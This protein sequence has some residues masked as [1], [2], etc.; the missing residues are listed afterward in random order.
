MCLESSYS[1]LI[2]GG[3]REEV[4]SHLSQGLPCR[5]DLQGSMTLLWETEEQEAKCWEM[6]DLLDPAGLPYLIL[7]P[8]QLWASGLVPFPDAY[9]P[10][11]LH[12]RREF[13]YLATQ[14]PLTQGF[15]LLPSS[16]STWYFRA[17]LCLTQV[18]QPARATI[19]PYEWDLHSVRAKSSLVCSHKQMIWKYHW[20]LMLL[21]PEQDS[22]GSTSSSST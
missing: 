9:L 20:W 22:Q 10:V 11:E 6:T 12:A 1:L 18:P 3:K 14:H 4:F 7:V 8:V 17:S 2:G 19:I 13:P 21:A 16:S 15:H 5:G